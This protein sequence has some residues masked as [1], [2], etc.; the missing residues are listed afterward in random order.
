MPRTLPTVDPRIIWNWGVCETYQDEKFL[1]DILGGLALCL[2]LSVGIGLAILQ[3][4][5]PAALAWA[6]ALAGA[7]SMRAWFK[8]EK[9]GI[10]R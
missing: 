2:G 10:A 8:R 1:L 4:P 6:I 7:W 9:P 3:R 5:G